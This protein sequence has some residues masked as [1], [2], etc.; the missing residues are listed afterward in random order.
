MLLIGSGV[1]GNG[2][3]LGRR[4]CIVRRRPGLAGRAVFY[5]L[6]AA[7]ALPA[8]LTRGA[9]L[10]LQDYYEAGAAIDVIHRTAATVGTAPATLTRGI[11]DHPEYSRTK[12][13]SLQRAM[14]ARSPSTSG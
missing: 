8:T 14:P 3:E 5:G 12:I 2:F 11:L 7:N 13:G 9:T 6:G 10:V 4:R 1:V